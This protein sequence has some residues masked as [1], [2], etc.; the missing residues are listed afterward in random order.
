MIA[1][2]EEAFVAE[3]GA[4]EE[5][6]AGDGDGAVRDDPERASRS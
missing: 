3:K 2:L 5:E 1:E 4:S 6:S